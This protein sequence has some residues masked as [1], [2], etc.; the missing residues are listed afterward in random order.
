MGQKVTTSACKQALLQSWPQV[1]GADLADQAA[2]WKR[3][4][5]S[6]KKGEP[7]ERVFYH[8]SL[9][10]QAMVIENDGVITKTVIRGFASF[11]ADEESM[12][13][14]EAQMVERSSTN[15]AFD[16]FSK[17]HCFKPSDFTFQMC[18]EEEAK[19]D[20]TWY[21]LFPTS[22]FGRGTCSYDGQV[23]YLIAAYLPEGDGEV[24]EGTF[25]TER[26][27]LEA[28]AELV[29]CGFIAESDFVPTSRSRD[30]GEDD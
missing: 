22:D 6:G 15:A 18:T 23:D 28:K 21:L 19:R 2:K 17:Y 13:E 1:F 27:V 9:P 20:G 24:T 30:G 7:I 29:R 8:Q 5:K 25:A 3:I 12:S 4:S 16:F 26:S 14:A 11:D 10:L